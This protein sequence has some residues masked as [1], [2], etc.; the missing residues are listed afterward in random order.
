MHPYCS[1]SYTRQDLSGVYSGYIFAKLR[2]ARGGAWVKRTEVV[3][4]MS[5]MLLAAILYWDF[6]SS[7]TWMSHYKLVFGMGYSLLFRVIELSKLTMTH[8][9]FVSVA[10]PK[11]RFPTSPV[12]QFTVWV[13]GWS[14]AHLCFYLLTVYFKKQRRVSE[15]ITLWILNHV[16]LLTIKR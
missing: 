15:K 12:N 4:S 9:H 7:K 11:P 16:C 13:S 8:C 2:W 1:I 14:I 10:W 3:K 6:N 5:E